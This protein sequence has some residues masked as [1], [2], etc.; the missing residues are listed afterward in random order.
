LDLISVVIPVYNVELYLRE[1]IES[2][3]AQTYTNIE[4]LLINDGST[5][6]CPSICD[7]Y[8]KIDKRVKVMHKENDGQ[9][10]ARNAGIGMANGEFIAFIDSDD[11]V[12]TDYISFMYDNIL[13]HQA[14]IS[15]CGMYI[16]NK[17]G[18]SVMF[19]GEDTV[20]NKPFEAFLNYTDRKMYICSPVNKLYKSTLFKNIRFPEGAVCEDLYIYPEILRAAEKVI[21]S[22]YP[23][24]YYRQRKSSTMHSY[25]DKFLNDFLSAHEN[26][27]RISM[28]YSK[29]IQKACR[30]NSTYECLYYIYKSESRAVYKKLVENIRRNIILVIFSLQIAWFHKFSCIAVCFGYSFYRFVLSFT[31]II[32]PNKFIS[33]SSQENKFE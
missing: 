33:V 8:L 2:V 27:I 4:I 26:I 23:K 7:E 1:C 22:S 24:Y 3:T 29:K 6:S 19:S 12:T 32:F 16:E 18:I 25:S 15:T 14:D 10:S 28:S 9:S 13:K 31:K 11:R 20:L 5:D 17:N 30:A 21:F